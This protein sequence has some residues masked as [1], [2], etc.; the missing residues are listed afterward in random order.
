[1]A[2]PVAAVSPADRALGVLGRPR[3]CRDGP[4]RAQGAPGLVRRREGDRRRHSAAE[5]T[6]A[7][8]IGARR[9]RDAGAV[10]RT[11]SVRMS[12]YPPLYKSTLANGSTVYVPLVVRDGRVGCHI[13]WKDATSAATITLEASSFD[14]VDAPVLTA[15]SAWLWK[16]TAV[17]IVGPSGAAAGA[18][19]VNVTGLYQRRARLK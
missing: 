10:T 7:V 18:A 14:Q 15:G 19:I 16:D 12:V 1:D 3:R 6:A 9:G 13:A 11:R 8:R 4:A 17:T 2:A 5:A